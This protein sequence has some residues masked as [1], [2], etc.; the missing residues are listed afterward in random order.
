MS[1]VIALLRVSTKAQQLASQREKVIQAILNDGYDES[2]IIPIEDTE[3][4]SQLDEEERSGINKLKHTIE[5]EQIASVYVYEISRLSRKET[6]LYSV[7]EYLQKHKV[8]LVCLNPPFV[9]FNP[10]WSISNAAAF[11]F[12]IFST[13]S[14]QETYIRTQ[15]VMRGKE[16]KKLEGKLSV[17]SP[18]YGYTLDSEHRPIPHP[19]ESVFVKEIFDRYVNQLESSG[20]IAKDLYLRKAFRDDSTKLLTIQNYVCVV[21]R[22]KRY[23]GLVESIYPPLVT[24]ELFYQAQKLRSKTGSKF[25]RKSNTKIIYPLQ[26]YLYTEDGYRLTIG[27]T[28]N[29][30]LKM[31]DASI[32]RISLRMDAADELSDIVISKYLERGI[33]QEENEK[34]RAKLNDTLRINKL[35]IDSILNKVESLLKENDLINLRII[36]GRINEAKGDALI[37]ENNKALMSLEDEKEELKYDNLKIENALITLANPLLNEDSSKEDMKLRQKVEKYIDKIIVRKVKFSTY[38]LEYH[39]KDGFVTTYSFYSI[40]RGVK[41]YNQDGVEINIK[42]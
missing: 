35:K 20:S 21:L 19:T 15:R 14:S 16:K 39:F 41:F 40:N 26:G 17:G 5:T 9:M 12:S 13:L 8:Q 2:D 24:K 42:E 33:V 11:T 18:L 38:S 36:K 3:S 6:V 22:E 31:N 34:V 23:A 4:A 32:S 30:Y 29:R 7:R 28:N 27:I 10:D 1:K 25:H 37:D